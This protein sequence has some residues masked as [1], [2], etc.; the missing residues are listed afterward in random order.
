MHALVHL[1]TK[2]EKITLEEIDEIMAPYYEGNVY[3]YDPEKDEYTEPNPYPQFGWDYYT[4]AQKVMFEKPEDC[5]VLI[6]PNGKAIAR[7]WW[8]GKKHVNQNKK[9]ETFCKKNRSKW[10]GLWMCEIDI[11]W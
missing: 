6:D 11:H 5:F 8:N 4:V 7:S 1:I 3:K 9:F 10:K 2:K